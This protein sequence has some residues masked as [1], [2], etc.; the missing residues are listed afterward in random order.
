VN[1][2]LFYEKETKILSTCLGMKI[3]VWD[4]KGNLIDYIKSVIVNEI[5]YSDKY[6]SVFIVAPTIKAIIVYDF[7]SKSEKDKILINET[8]V[9]IAISKLDRGNYL[10]INISNSTP[11]LILLDISNKTIIRKYFGHRQEKLTTK[12]S[13]GGYSEKFLICG[14][15]SKEIFIWNRSCSIPVSVIKAH[16]GCVNTAIWHYSTFSSLIISGSDDHTIK[17]FSNDNFTKAIFGAK[18]NFKNLKIDD[19]I[20]YNPIYWNESQPELLH[21]NQIIRNLGE[22]E[23]YLSNQVEECVEDF[24][25]EEED[26]DDNEED[27]VGEDDMEYDEFAQY[28]SEYDEINDDED[29]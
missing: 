25:N 23:N 8:I 10:L 14:S 19:K 5:L 28:N 12:C 9:S 2:V 21:F 18:D 24:E 15:D 11:A 26:D 20:K 17:V 29:N 6:D 13:F 16:A 22:E 3:K 4:L 7:S 27:E 1:S